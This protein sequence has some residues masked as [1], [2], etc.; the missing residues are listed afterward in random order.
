MLKKPSTGSNVAT[1]LMYWGDWD[2]GWI[3]TIYHSPTA[4]VMT[5]GWRSETFPLA[6]GIRQ[7]CPL[8]P[9][10]FALAL[11]PLAE[12]IRLHTE[13]RGVRMGNME[14]KIALYADDILLFL[15]SPRQ[16]VSAILKIF[17]KFSLISGYTINLTKSEAMPLGTLS[18]TD[19]AYNF[20]FNGLLAAS[21]ISE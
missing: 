7:G 16:T 2:W 6:R 13:V 4:S 12:S 1:C 19:V 8:S 9:L 10:L 20:P 15:T 3:R 18:L 11:E 17:H 14:H 5:N 21:H